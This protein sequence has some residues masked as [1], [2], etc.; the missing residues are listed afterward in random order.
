MKD[1]IRLDGRKNSLTKEGYPIFI[2]LT[3]KMDAKK[4]LIIKT[5]YYAFK[6]H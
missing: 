4:E 5:G 1:K 2:Y 3:N 6:E